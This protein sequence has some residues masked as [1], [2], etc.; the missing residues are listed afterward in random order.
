MKH[1]TWKVFFVFSNAF[2]I[3]WI[4]QNC[5][6]SSQ[7]RGRAESASW[8]QSDHHFVSLFM[9]R[10]K[11]VH[12]FQF[13]FG[14]NIVNISMKYFQLLRL[15]ITSTGKR[16][17]F[18][19]LK[20]SNIS[21]YFLEEDS[22]LKVLLSG[23]YEPARKMLDSSENLHSSSWVFSWRNLVMNCSLSQLVATTH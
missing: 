18:V 14:G 4:S 10:L 22:A 2:L 17:E 21:G 11:T 15:A 5:A 3:N 1:F 8:G 13:Q 7:S 9:S 19:L 6:G 20:F 23:F 12:T 16:Q